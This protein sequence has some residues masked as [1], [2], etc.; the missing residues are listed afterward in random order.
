VWLA[1]V[2]VLVQALIP[3]VVAAEITLATSLGLEVGLQSCPFGHLH[4]AALPTPAVHTHDGRPD[5]DAPAP[6]DRSP[7]NGGLAD[8]CAICIALHTGG[9]F[10]APAEIH[11]AA[12]LAQPRA[13]RETECSDGFCSL[14]V[15]TAYHA[16][17]PP[18]MG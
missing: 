6:T 2:A 1:F 8:G 14:A 10:V 11:I 7:D 3:N 4:V 18:L 5:G 17:A 15:S 9:Q 16:R 13:V 12:P